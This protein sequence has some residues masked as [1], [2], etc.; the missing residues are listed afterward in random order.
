M[1]L[2]KILF[3]LLLA[4]FLMSCESN[5]EIVEEVILELIG[6]ETVEIEEGTEYEDLGVL[7]NGEKVDFIGYYSN[8][9]IDRVGTY[10]VKYEYK[11]V[12]I[13]RTVKVI[14]GAR[15]NLLAIILEF[16]NSTNYSYTLDLDV[17]FTRGGVDFHTFIYEDYDVNEDYM[18]GLEK[19]TSYNMIEYSQNA[20]IYLDIAN[21]IEE[22]YMFDEYSFW[23]Q[24]RMYYSRQASN[25]TDFNLSGIRSVTK[26][27]KDGQT[28]YTGYLN[29][30][31]YMIAYNSKINLIPDENF[32]FET[33]DYITIIITV[34]DDQIVRIESDLLYVMRNTISDSSNAIPNEYKYVYTFS[35]Y[36]Q[37]EEIIIPEEGVQARRL[38]HPDFMGSGTVEDP[39]IVMDITQFQ[40]IGDNLDKHFKLGVDI[41]L[42]E[43][44][45]MPFGMFKD[46][47][48]QPYSFSGTLDGNGHSINNMSTHGQLSMEYYGLFLCIDGGSIK[49]LSHC[50]L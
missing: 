37:V 41:D 40:L 13:L 42:S 19:R 8:I 38:V 11:S 12:E 28:V 3:V 16:E 32:D 29:F 39:Y 46:M 23:Y 18:F 35:N 27:D 4:F 7:L 36:N 44:S 10:Y 49:N 17:H 50:K 2:G 30:E 31:D 21:N 48:G 24:D 22:H 5:N 43:Y 20:Y 6:D 25:V 9:N 47:I 34:E 45:W 33:D 1:R 15:T 26:E 14:E